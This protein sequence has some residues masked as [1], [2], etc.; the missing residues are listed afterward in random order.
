MQFNT[1]GCIILAA[2]KHIVVILMKKSG[3]N[4]PFYIILWV[5]KLQETAERVSYLTEKL[6]HSSSNKKAE[7]ILVLRTHLGLT[8]ALNVR[9]TNLNPDTLCTSCDYFIITTGS[10][11]YPHQYEKC[12]SSAYEASFP[13]RCQII[14]LL[15]T[16]PC[17]FPAALT[18]LCQV[19]TICLM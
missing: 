5:C 13:I 15:E 16:G 19:I 4:S 10:L 9:L 18:D 17:C 3:N 8:I 7:M 12:T 6:Q 11:R 2:T 1:R 14:V